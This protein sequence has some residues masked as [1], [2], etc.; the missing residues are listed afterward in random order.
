MIIEYHRP[1]TLDEALA[2]IS[3]REP[4]TVPLGG[5]TALNRPSPN[6]LAVVDLQSLGLNT[7]N[8]RGKNLDLGATLGLQALLDVSGIPSVLHQVIRHEAT[9]N[10]RQMATIAGT[11]VACDG[12]SPF[13][14][15]L[16][17]LDA[18]ITLQPGEEQISLGDLLPIRN[19]ILKGRLITKVTLPINMQ[20]AYNYVARSPA[21]LPIVC[22]AV[23]IWPSGRIRVTLGGYG[24]APVLA[25]DGP[26][27]EGAGI[28]AR[29][30]YRNSTDEWASVDYRSEV[31]EILT[32]RCLEEL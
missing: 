31:A 18:Q 3:R 11:L 25:M 7:I 26:G 6:P 15:A 14:T 32:R 13:S 28:S 1:Q 20:L 29:D 8:K 19:D 2:L 24:D 10:L 4:L 22:V 16:L 23:S 30:A 27:V 9:Y 12:R 21:D 5:G 17:A